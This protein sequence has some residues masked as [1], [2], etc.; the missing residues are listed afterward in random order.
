MVTTMTPFL[1]FEGRAEEAIRF[2]V[3]TV[4][5]SELVA[6]APWTEGGP[7]TPGKVMRGSARIGGQ[8][9]QFSDSPV[10][11][12]FTFTPSLSLFVDCASEAELDRLFAA[13]SEGGQTLMP[14][15]AYGFSKKFCWVNDRFGVSWQ[16][17][18]P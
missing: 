3:A 15:G 12:A 6:I 5:H 1:M 16:L 2:Y 9:V 10:K 11:H 7:G 4:P 14:L 18:L 13:F 8:L 17:N